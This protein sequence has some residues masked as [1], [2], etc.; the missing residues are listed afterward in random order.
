MGGM[1]Q[2][3]S[4]VPG[5]QEAIRRAGSQSAL[6]RMLGKTQPHIQKWLRSPNP[7]RPEHCR[8]IEMAVGVTRP[9]LRPDDWADIW[10]E[11]K[12]TSHA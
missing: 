10:P 2:R 11:L 12:D 3:N 9:Q 8:A 7:V 5:L 1:N 4:S 6:A